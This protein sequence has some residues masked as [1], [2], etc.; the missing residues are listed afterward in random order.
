MNQTNNLDHRK[1]LQL[2]KA[3]MVNA[4][5]SFL[6]SLVNDA[7]AELIEAEFVVRFDSFEITRYGASSS[8]DHHPVYVYQW[9]PNKNKISSEILEFD[10]VAA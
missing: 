2:Q 8:A 1:N 9:E 5:E 7:Y 3:H 4:V 10:G 6:S